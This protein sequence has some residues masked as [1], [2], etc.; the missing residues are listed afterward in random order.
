MLEIEKL[1]IEVN[2]IREKYEYIIRITGEKFNV[3]EILGL[4]TSEVRLHSS[5]IA[6]LLDTK[7]SHGQG[8]KFLLLFIEQL[9]N[10]NQNSDESEKNQII[11]TEFD[12]S[13]SRSHVEYF[14]SKISENGENGGRIDI[15]VEDSKKKHIIIEN[16]IYALDQ[17]SQL[18]RYKNFDKNAILLYLNLI[19]DKPQKDSYIDLEINKDF[20]IISYKEHILPWLSNCLKEATSLPSIRETIHQYINLI[21]KLTNQSTYQTMKEDIVTLIT[22]NSG[23]LQNAKELANNFDYAKAKILW[24][25]WNELEKALIECQIELEKITETVNE[26]KTK[27]CFKNKFNESSIFF[28]LYTKEVY[29]KDDI[30]IR[31]GCELGLNINVGFI[32]WEKGKKG[33]A[34]N[35]NFTESTQITKL[36]HDCDEKYKPF[37]HFLGF[38]YSEPQL[39]FDEF[40]SEEI[41]SLADGDVLKQTVRKIAEKAKKDIQFFEENLKRYIASDIEN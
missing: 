26:E 28:G 5:F 6:E 21:K 17:P 41:F 4:Q 32:I 24:N 22:K 27:N 39:N 2:A 9:K 23:N 34:V 1:L 12:Y 8:D 20:H 33:I 15:L 13:S 30:V 35:S 19:G 18:K 36:I 11:I 16:K 37:K 10:P 3:F 29:R 7:G 31:W 38:Q 40:K 25:F 14:T